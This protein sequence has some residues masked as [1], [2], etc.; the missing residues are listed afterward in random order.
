M[1][2]HVDNLEA[3]SEALKLIRQEKA[4]AFTQGI[5]ATSLALMAVL[6][7]KVAVGVITDELGE[8]ILNSVGDYLNKAFA[9]LPEDK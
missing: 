7:A 8:N 3:N 1:S 5:K 2:E 6:K 4:D 9:A